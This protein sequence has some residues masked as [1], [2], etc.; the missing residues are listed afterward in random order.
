MVFMFNDGSD[1]LNC[2][3]FSVVPSVTNV[4]VK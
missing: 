2:N 1:I 4:S 3:T